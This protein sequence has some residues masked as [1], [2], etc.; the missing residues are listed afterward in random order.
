MRG[1][2]VTAAILPWIPVFSA[3]FFLF[4]LTPTFRAV[5][6][7]LAFLCHEGGHVAAFCIV[8]EGVPRLSAVSGGFRLVSPAC[9]S[10]RSER[11]VAL[12]GPAANLIPGLLFLAFGAGNPY[13][14]EAGRIFI[15]T[16]LSNLIPIADHDGG[17]VLFCLLSPRVGYARAA[18]VASAVSWGTSVGWKV[19]KLTYSPPSSGP[20][21]GPAAAQ[22]PRIRARISTSGHSVL[23]SFFTFPLL[24][25]FLHSTIPQNPVSVKH[26][27]AFSQCDRISTR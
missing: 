25:F 22:P 11:F 10:Y 3:V 21:C 14:A 12:A 9:L 13:A 20:P 5:L 1:G 2:R 8:G 26:D 18:S 24:C 19:W 6:L 27:F 23:N 7:L 15:G 17:R 16:G 4:R